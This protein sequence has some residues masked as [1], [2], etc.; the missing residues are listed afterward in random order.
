MKELKGQGC[1]CKNCFWLMKHE[2]GEGV[3]SDYYCCA[4][5]WDIDIEEKRLDKCICHRYMFIK[6]EE[7]EN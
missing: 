5:K 1:C 2:A 6:S 4:T 3:I 7:K